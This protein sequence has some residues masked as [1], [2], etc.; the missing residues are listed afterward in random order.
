MRRG[1]PNDTVSRHAAGPDHR[2]AR[3]AGRGITAHAAARLGHRT[4]VPR[5]G[6]ARGLRR[7]RRQLGERLDTL[8]RAGLI[9]REIAVARARVRVPPQ[10]HPGGDVR[11]DPAPRSARAPPPGRR[12]PRG[13]VREPAR[14]VRAAARPPSLEGGR[15]RADAPVRDGR[16]RQRGPA[17]RERRGR[18]PLRGRDRGRAT[19]RS[20][21]RRSL[22][23]LYP[24][25]GRALELAGRFD[26]AVANYEEMRCYAEER[27][28][29][30]GRARSRRCR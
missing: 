18:H 21:P 5:A 6:A 22:H 11:D 19:S 20:R 30:D 23:H 4:H 8:E 24:S 26:E 17:V 16:R 28:R 12:G 2:P 25:R 10:P 3:H 9:S 29:P 1:G 7:R 27:R 15:R 14:G 13:A